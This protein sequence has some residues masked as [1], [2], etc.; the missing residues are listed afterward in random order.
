MK[1]NASGYKK[2]G[3]IDPDSALEHL[4]YDSYPVFHLMNDRGVSE[5]DKYIQIYDEPSIGSVLYCRR[6]TGTFSCVCDVKLF[7]F[8]SHVLPLKLYFNDCGWFPTHPL[9]DLF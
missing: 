9:V 6:F 8:D 2:G 7:P 3:Y 4:D 1:K 5:V